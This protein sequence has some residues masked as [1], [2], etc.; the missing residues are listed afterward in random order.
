MHASIHDYSSV[1]FNGLLDVEE[2]ENR[3]ERTGHLD[4]MLSEVGP[5][6]AKHGTWRDWGICLLHKHWSIENDEV[7]V[8]RDLEVGGLKHYVLEPRKVREQI[9]AKPSILA[10]AQDDSGGFEP[11]EFSKS[12]HTLE[13]N[14]SLERQKSFLDELHRVMVANGLEEIFGL[15]STIED[16]KA[17]YKFVEMTEPGRVSVLR[18]TPVDEV[19]SVRL[20]ETSWRFVP[21]EVSLT[22][23][24]NCMATC[25]INTDGSHYNA[26][27]LK[28]HQAKP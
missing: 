28:Q 11:L 16:A 25:G 6:F 14:E 13:T 27:H 5:L 4:D 24:K 1:R 21:T 17:G 19:R 15:I 12:S 8:Q 20:I 7:P 22:C 2:A 26:G 3:L 9:R 23:Q 10:V 18:E